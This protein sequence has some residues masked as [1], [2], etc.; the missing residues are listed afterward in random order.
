MALLLWNRSFFMNIEIFAPGRTLWT[1]HPILDS[2]HDELGNLL[3]FMVMRLYVRTPFGIS[4]FDQKMR[5]FSKSNLPLLEVM[6]TR[7]H[8]FHV[9]FRPFHLS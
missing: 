8:A 3:L 2:T 5:F 9:S 6:G 4:H 1:P 7:L